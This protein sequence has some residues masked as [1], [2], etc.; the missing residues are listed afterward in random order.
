[1]AT[2][3]DSA[4]ANQTRAALFD[5]AAVEAIAATMNAEAEA[6]DEYRAEPIGTRGAYAVVL[7]NDGLRLGVV[8]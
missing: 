4:F 2:L 1:M 6:G 3:L 7:Y 5:V 8:A